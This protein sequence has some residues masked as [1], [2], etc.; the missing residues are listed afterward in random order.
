[1]QVSETLFILVQTKRGRFEAA[2]RAAALLMR[3]ARRETGT[4]Y[5]VASDLLPTRN[6][7][8]RGMDDEQSR[9]PVTCPTTAIALPCL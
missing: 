5:L 7:N 9:L 3:T 8:V 2:S 4:T 6:G 1:M